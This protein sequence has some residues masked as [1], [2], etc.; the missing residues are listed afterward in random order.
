MKLNALLL[1]PLF[2]LFIFSAVIISSENLSPDMQCLKNYLR[3]SFA[4]NVFC[5]RRLKSLVIKVIRLVC[6]LAGHIY[7]ELFEYARV[8]L[9]D[10]Y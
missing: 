10:D 5:V 3:V 9:R 1:R 2:S 6:R 4:E 8:D 7:F